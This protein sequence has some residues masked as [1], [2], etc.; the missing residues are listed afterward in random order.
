[1]KMKNFLHKI[2]L[3]F[4]LFWIISSVSYN[5]GYVLQFLLV[6]TVISVLLRIIQRRK[7]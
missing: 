5:A 2:V 4:I 1:M 6:S 3:V 7:N